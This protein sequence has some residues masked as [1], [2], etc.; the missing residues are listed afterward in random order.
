MSNT[1]SPGAEHGLV[2]PVR[3]DPTGNAGP[4]RGQ[5]AGPHWRRS[6][7]GLYV[8]SAVPVT[9]EQR[10]LEV[11]VLVPAY[12]AVTG[13]AALCWCRGHWFT[14]HARDGIATLPVP[15]VCSRRRIRPQQQLQLCEERLSQREIE[16]VDGI[17]V[18]SM[19]RSTAFAM[20][21]APSLGDAV[22]ALDLACFHDLVSI[23]EVAHWVARHRSWTGIEQARRALPLGDENA[24]SPREVGMRLDWPGGPVLT[25]RPVFDLQGRHLATPDLID[26]V[27]GVFG[28]YESS[29]HLTGARRAKDLRREEELRSH[30]LEPVTMVAADVRAPGSYHQRVRSAYARAE[31]RPASERRWTLDL[32]TSWVPTFTV[33]QRR[34]LD[35]TERAIWLRLRTG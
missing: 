1:P 2:A 25:N 18:T 35:E 27:A 26:P 34:A 28:E 21:Y 11:G 14:G 23:E 16:V 15:V 33:S 13:W 3:R 6:T 20:R 19:A 12:G 30:G 31:R 29:L 10:V 7:Y 17:R 32:P 5:P 9:P 4:T 24:W 22:V 8:P